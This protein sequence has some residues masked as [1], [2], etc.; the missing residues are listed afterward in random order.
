MLV[1]SEEA[2]VNSGEATSVSQKKD[3]YIPQMDEDM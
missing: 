2:T 1:N 3:V